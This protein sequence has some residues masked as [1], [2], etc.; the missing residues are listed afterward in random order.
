MSQ[1]DLSTSPVHGSRCVSGWFQRAVA[2]SIALLCL[3]AATSAQPA[4]SGLREGDR[5]V[6]VGDSIT[7]QSVGGNGYVTLMREALR[8]VHPDTKITLTPLGGSGHGVGSWISVEKD[9]RERNLK[10]DVP[11]VDIKTTLDGGADVIIIMLGMNNV[12]SPDIGNTA[13]DVKKWAAN[14]RTLIAALRERT[15]PRIIALATPTLCT[16]DEAS[17][18]NVMMDQLCF[19]MTDLAKTNDCTVLPVRD[20]F[21]AFLREGRTYRPD[22]HVTQDFVHPNAA[23]HLAIAMSMLEGLGEKDAAKWI[24][25]SRS[26]TI[27]KAAAGT[28][29]AVSYTLTPVVKQENAIDNQGTFKVAFWFT[30]S[31]PRKEDA[32]RPHVQLTAPEGWTVTPASLDAASGSFTVSGPLDRLRNVLTITARQGDIATKAQVVIPPPWL[33]GVGNCGVIGWS[34]PGKGFIF[35][36]DKGRLPIDAQLAQG[37][38]FDKPVPETAGIKWSRPIKWTRTIAN[39][40]YT[41]GASP[42]SVDVSAASWFGTFEVAYGCRWIYSPTD[43]TLTG[44]FGSRIFAGTNFLSVWLNGENVR[45]T[46]ERKGAANL[47]LTKGWNALVFKSNHLSWQWQ[48]DIDLVPAAGESL[49]DLRFSITPPPGATVVP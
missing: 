36:P 5:V 46:L 4:Q 17:T 35:D 3:V 13:D 34:N 37:I 20:K 28:L 24:Y 33:I 29:P 48:F 23:G 19:A 21:R 2:V 16:E 30:N 38:G 18:K 27:W 45:A 43:R 47:K 1:F 7:G 8:H 25:E 15:H 14:Y 22:F 49:E 11:D 42:G 10:L 26:P 31:V 32:A 41:G 39:V 44:A 9:S 6:V 12:L 40:N